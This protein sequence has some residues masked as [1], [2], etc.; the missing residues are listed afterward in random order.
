MNAT[1]PFRA[2]ADLLDEKYVAWKSDHRS[3]EPAWAS[4]F[5]G[6][7]LGLAQRE[8]ADG[9]RREGGG[10]QLS[11]DAIA[12]RSKVTNAILDFRRNGHTAAWLDPLSKGPPEQ[13]SLAPAGL[14]FSE[15]ELD[16]E[17]ATQFHAQGRPTK[18]RV[19]LEEL[20]QIY[21]DRIGFE[22]MHIHNREVRDWLRERIE[23]RLHEPAPSAAR[24]KDVL[25]WLLRGGDVRAVPAQT[26]RRAE[27]LLARR[28]RVADGRAGDDPGGLPGAGRAGNRDGHGAS[29]TAERAREF[30]EEAAQGAVLRVL[31]ELRARTWSRATAT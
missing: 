15:A 29:R 9:A 1:L 6:F 27:A 5:E 19:M 25:R 21:C 3:V 8:L 26:L 10:A 16:E 2:N 28:R 23:A 12:F 11:D 30:P 22:F 7:E 13:P 20:R 24:Q 18:L 14:G 31:R 17:V 4:F